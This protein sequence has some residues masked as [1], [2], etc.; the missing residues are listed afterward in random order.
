MIIGGLIA[1]DLVIK[2]PLYA[3]SLGDGGF[4]IKTLQKT[5]PRWLYDAAWLQT[6]LGGGIELFA[7]MFYCL[8]FFPRSRF[9]YAMAVSGIAMAI[10][11]Q[12]K[13][14]FADPRPYHVDP[15]IIPFNCKP[16]FGNPSGHSIASSLTAFVVYM[17]IFHGVPV[18]FSFEGDN[19]YHSGCKQ[20]MAWLFAVY[21]TLTIP[22]TRYFGGVHSLDQVIFGSLL[23]LVIGVYCHF[24][25]RD[26]IIW[27]FE[28]VIHWHDTERSILTIVPKNIFTDGD[29]E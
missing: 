4:S 26:N 8:F 11:L 23:G 18:T 5:L 28:T 20:F 16:T 3:Y 2:D 27:F 12:L 14:S 1:L 6:N 24:V 22:F 10:G 7:Y 19:I 9:F 17:D 25:V 21:W 13:L 15:K 29:N